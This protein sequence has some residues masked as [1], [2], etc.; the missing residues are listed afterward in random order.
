MLVRRP[1]HTKAGTVSNQILS[2]LDC[3]PMKTTLG[4]F[5]DF[6]EGSLIPRANSAMF[7]SAARYKNRKLYC[8]L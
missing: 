4:C 3:L 5:D 2:T 1:E 6:L 7:P 8:S